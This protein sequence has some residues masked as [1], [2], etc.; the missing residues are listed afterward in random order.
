MIRKI[1][2]LLSTQFQKELESAYIYLFFASYFDSMGLEGFSHWYKKQAEEEEEHAMKFYDYLHEQDEELKF[3][4]IEAPKLDK[5][6]V[7]QV[8]NETLEHEEYISKLIDDIYREAI[9]EK[10]YATQSFLNWFIT[11]QRE[12]ERQVQ[13]IITRFNLFCLE[14]GNLYQLDCELGKR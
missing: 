8:L 4:P 6:S 14:G 3:L 10:D 7:I 12:E 2:A 1:S 9:D 11:E 5:K 13:D